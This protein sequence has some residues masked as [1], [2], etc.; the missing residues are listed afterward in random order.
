MIISKGGNYLLD[1]GPTALGSHSGGGRE[2]SAEAAGRWLKVN[3]DAVYGA[4][5][6]PFGEGFGGFGRKFSM[7]RARKSISRFS[8]GDAP[9]SREALFHHLPLVGQ[10]V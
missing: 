2:K 8:I 5:R 10:R 1:V 7:A 3:G 4:G 9:P 6:S